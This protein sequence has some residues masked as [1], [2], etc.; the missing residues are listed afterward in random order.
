[1]DMIEKIAVFLK[2]ILDWLKSDRCF[3]K[4]FIEAFKLTNSNILL[5]TLLI[6]FV[7][8]ITVYLIVAQLYAINNILSLLIVTLMTSALASGFFHSMKKSIKYY[9]DNTDN[10]SVSCGTFYSG[11]GKHYLSFFSITVTFF[12]LASLVILGT[13]VLANYLV[14]DIS[15][16]NIDNNFF[17]LLANPQAIDFSMLDTKQ[18]L[19]FR[20]WNR[21]F[22]VTT[23]LF[24][25]M[26]M[27]WIPEKM[28]FKKDIFSSLF[29][30]IKKIF[31]DLPNAICIYLTIILLNYI[32]AIFTV[33]CGNNSIAVFLLSVVSFYL[34]TYNFYAIFL[35]YKAK[36][37]DSY[38]RTND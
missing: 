16:L 4:Y 14:C 21:V 31:S 34:L 20:N 28:Y 27:Y 33:I 11:I 32:L 10:K 37:V 13:F 9:Y 19:Y 24:T 26:I 22:L 2:N 3:L 36:F 6:L 1:M 8:T 30:G 38:E 18:Q 35:Y 7:F 12:V 23:Q 29:E 5:L 15:E 17:L 25:F